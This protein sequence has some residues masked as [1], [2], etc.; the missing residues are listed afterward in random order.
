LSTH[1]GRIAHK[2]LAVTDVFLRPIRK[3]TKHFSGRKKMLRSLAAVRWRT[4]TYMLGAGFL[5]FP[6]LFF[7]YITPFFH[8]ISLYFVYFIKNTYTVLLENLINS[9]GNPIYSEYL[10]ISSFSLQVISS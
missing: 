6:I 7:I 3:N 8:N 4:V 2:V 10:R 9:Y 5:L 1:F